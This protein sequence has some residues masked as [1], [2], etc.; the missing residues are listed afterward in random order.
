[1]SLPAVEPL[2]M[3]A[4]LVVARVSACLMVAP[5]FSSPR[6][7]G[8]A[9][10]FFAIALSVLI[11]P[12][13]RDSLAADAAAAPAAQA[14]ALMRETA[15]G[16]T[17]GIV[18]RVYLLAFEMMATAMSNFVGLSAAFAPS[19]EADQPMPTLASALALAATMLVFA[20]GLDAQLIRALVGSYTAFP[21]DVV[22]QGLFAQGALAQ[23][24]EAL[25]DATLIGLRIAAP[26][27]VMALVAN[28]A[29]GA[30]SRFTPQAPIYFVAAPVLIGLGLAALIVVERPAFGLLIDALG[31][32]LA[33]W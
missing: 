25:K 6:V 13:A 32:R 24:V 18:A 31:A 19:P 26:L 14:L 10:L 4:A 3:S 1:V 7:T 5:G 28:L 29:F 33:S 27:L 2:I 21:P 23:V 9:R 30:A 12:L 8:R 16:A 20:S 11:E 22:A 17:L 15:I